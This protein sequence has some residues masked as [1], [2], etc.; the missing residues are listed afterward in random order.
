[1]QK[2]TPAEE[3]F[4]DDHFRYLSMAYQGQQ[5]LEIVDGSQL[6]TKQDL[7]HV[8]DRIH[9]F[10]ESELML[11][12]ASIFAKRYAYY[13]VTGPLALMSAF[14][15]FP[16]VRFENF[17]FVRM[18]EAKKWLPKFELIDKTVST[19]G[20]GERREWVKNSLETLF[21]QNVRPLFLHLNQMTRLSMN[22]LWENFAIYLYWFYEL[23]AQKLFEGEQ[24]ARI[25]DDFHMMLNEFDGDVFGEEEN[26]FFYFQYQTKKPTGKRERKYCCLTYRKNES[27]GY[28]KTCPH[29]C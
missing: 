5:P 12:T 1:M 7:Q 22:V 10:M 14:D 19:P 2:L 26:P 29:R 13:M 23:E 4:L 3:A 16:D 24:L 25:R 6:E 21:K 9:V 28:C 20:E 17:R 27:S 11:T 8:L 18:D 15:K